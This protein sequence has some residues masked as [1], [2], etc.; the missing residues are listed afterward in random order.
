M[1]TKSGKPEVFVPVKPPLDSP[2]Q[3]PD[4]EGTYYSDELSAYY[5]ISLQ[6]GSLALR[7]GDSLETRLVPLYAD[8]FT[9][10]DGE[11]NLSFTRDAQGK[12]TGFVF[13]MAG[14]KRQVKG[15]TFQ[16]RR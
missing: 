2:Q 9:I 16:R 7:V 11:I 3:L 10:P 14:E 1:L 5:K 12:I 6:G 8:F 13:S 15:I 4:Y